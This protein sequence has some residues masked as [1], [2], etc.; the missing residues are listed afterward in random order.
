MK[1]CSKDVLNNVCILQ[2]SEKAQESVM[3]DQLEMVVP[4]VQEF[5]VRC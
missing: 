1:S 4:K 3:T 5:A 2:G